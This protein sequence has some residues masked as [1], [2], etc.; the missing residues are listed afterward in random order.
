MQ[1]NSNYDDSSSELMLRPIFSSFPFF[2]LL[3]LAFGLMYTF[4]LYRNPCGITYPLFTAFAC[5]CGVFACKKLLLPMKKDSWFLLAAAMLLGIATCRTS[6]SFLIL[7]NGI[8]LVLLGC[9]FAL[10]QFYDDTAWNIG[11]YL[12]SIFLY[13]YHAMGALFVPFRHMAR[14]MKSQDN[15]LVRQLP[16]LLLGFLAALPV[17]AVVIWLLGAADAVFFNLTADI[18]NKILRPDLLIRLFFHTLFAVLALYC[19]MCS[20]CLHKIREDTPDRSKVS[21]VIAITGL[22][23]TAFI[24]L[25]FCGIQVVYLFLGRGTLPAGYTYSGYARQGF[26][27]LLIVAVFNLVLVLCCLKYIR[28]HKAITWILTL[29]CVCTYVMIASAGYRMTLYVREYH[30]SYLR[31]LVIWFL[32]LLAVLMIGVTVI[33]WRQKFP[34]FRYGVLMVSVFYVALAWARPDSVIAWDYVNHLDKQEVTYEDLSYLAGSLS[35]DGAPAMASLLSDSSLSLSMA[36]D[37]YP[38]WLRNYY[39]AHVRPGYKDL[40]IRNYNFSFAQ[41]KR[42]FPE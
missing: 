36:D 5:F 10:H 16:L 3:S 18:F 35:A 30:L 29:I 22:S 28:P 23:M 14:Y 20:C 38:V 41:A 37:E 39:A 9:I 34:L 6:D 26:F 42:L 19:L 32:I 31:L 21:P 11:K 12:S 33:I 7:V 17:L 13:L 15:P 8:A 25:V 1:S 4:C 24:Y 2:A 27:Q 40:G